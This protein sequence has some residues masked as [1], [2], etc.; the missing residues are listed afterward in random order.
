MAKLA[1]STAVHTHATKRGSANGI[2]IEASGIKSTTET[3][4][5]TT[6]MGSSSTSDQPE[7]KLPVL[8]EQ[9]SLVVQLKQKAVFSL[10]VCNLEVIFFLA[11][12]VRSLNSHLRDNLFSI[13]GSVDHHY[14]FE[15]TLQTMQSSV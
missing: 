1:A 5:K 13:C 2:S 14:S 6:G 3:V 9:P 4:G 10:V 12:T 8:P 15:R 7:V 11:I